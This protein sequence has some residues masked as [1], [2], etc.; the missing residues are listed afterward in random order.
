[1]S[2]LQRAANGSG[3]LAHQSPYPF[4]ELAI[5]LIRVTHWWAR[6]PGLAF[7]ANPEAICVHLELALAL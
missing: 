7:A 2:K 4:I 6:K 5:L 1:M 3:A